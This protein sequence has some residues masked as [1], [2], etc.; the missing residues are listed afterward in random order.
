MAPA[1]DMKRAMDAVGKGS[2]TAGFATD[3][4]DPTNMLGSQDSLVRIQSFEEAMGKAEKKGHDLA[5]AGSAISEAFGA[6][7]SAI[8]GVGGAIASQIG[9]IVQLT[10]KFIGL[11]IAAAEASAAQNPVV[12]WIAAIG[13]GVGVAAS[14]IG[15]MGSVGAR[16][17]GGPIDAYQPY[18]VGERGPELVVPR[19]SGTVLPAGSFG[20]GGTS[21][22]IYALDSKSFADALDRND[23]VLVRK[24]DRLARAGRNG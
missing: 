19:S 13:A 12:G 2:H 10:L 5:D 22:S 7:G 8:G 18:L 9:N 11:A 1:Q 21:I 14:I 23:Q 6:V 4:V 20:G 16:A 3:M 15:L 24:L 17:D